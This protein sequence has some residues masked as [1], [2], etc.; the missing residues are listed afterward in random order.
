MNARYAIAALAVGL[1]AIG[2]QA[3]AYRAASSLATG[4][5]FFVASLD[6]LIVVLIG[7]AVSTLMLAVALGL[8]A[9]AKG[10]SVFLG[11]L[12]VFSCVGL[13]VVALLPDKTARNEPRQ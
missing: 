1:P 2:L 3:V 7:S 4:K 13:L 9:R 6:P 11:L 10:Q 8:Y 5:P 12:A